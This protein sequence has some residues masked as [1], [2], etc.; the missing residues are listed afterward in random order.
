MNKTNEAVAI[1]R[2]VLEQS[3]EMK[4][5]SEF[6]PGQRTKD[7]DIIGSGVGM[8]SWTIIPTG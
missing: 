8:I 1:R 3:T 2:S 4:P 6:D 7:V 5:V